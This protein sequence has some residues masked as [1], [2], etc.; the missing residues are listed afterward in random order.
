MEAVGPSE[1]P[2]P[3]IEPQ[4]LAFQKTIILTANETPRSVQVQGV[5][6]LLVKYGSASSDR[7]YL[8][9]SPIDYSEVEN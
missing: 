6:Y 9:L 3:S 1:M 4:G 8:H 2:V 5:I 7:S